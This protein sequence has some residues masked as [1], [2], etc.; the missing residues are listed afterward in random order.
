[1]ELN[2]LAGRAAPTVEQFKAAER[3]VFLKGL[4][5]WIREGQSFNV[6]AERDKLLGIKQAPPQ[7]AA[8]RWGRSPA[9]FATMME[10]MTIRGP[11]GEPFCSTEDAEVLQAA[12]VAWEIIEKLMKKAF[13]GNEEAAYR[14]ASLASHATGAVWHCAEQ[15]PELLTAIQRWNTSSGSPRNWCPEPARRYRIHAD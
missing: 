5:N 9:A 4:R 11:S 2:G 12:Q 3:T 6:M 1:M 13:E 15:A 7:S 14:L 10:A 8:E